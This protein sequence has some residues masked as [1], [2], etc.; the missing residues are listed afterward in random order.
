MKKN[1]NDSY[2]VTIRNK[3]WPLYFYY[4][5]LIFYLKRQKKT[6]SHKCSSGAT[7]HMACKNGKAG[8]KTQS[9]L[10]SHT[11]IKYAFFRWWD[12]LFARLQESEDKMHGTWNQGSVCKVKLH[13]GVTQYTRL[14]TPPS[15][16][17][18]PPARTTRSTVSRTPGSTVYWRKKQIFRSKKQGLDGKP[19]KWCNGSLV[20]IHYTYIETK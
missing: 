1:T 6:R 8:Q 14:Q 7:I 10:E 18:T 16:T 4:V 13:A 19:V 20:C 17:G 5:W 15:H 3:K 2:T 11:H 9:C 12:P